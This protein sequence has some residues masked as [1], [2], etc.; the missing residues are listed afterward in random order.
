MYCSRLRG[1][2]GGGATAIVMPLLAIGFMEHNRST[3]FAAWRWAFFIPGAIY[4]ILG[5]ITFV[6][7]QARLMSMRILFVISQYKYCH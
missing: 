6:F 5:V 4:L 1:N 3:P 2:M 7:A